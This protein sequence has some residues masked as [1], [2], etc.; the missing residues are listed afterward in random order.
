MAC[1]EK[2]YWYD[3]P[4]PP[5]TRYGRTGRRARLSFLT[6]NVF[7][8]VIRKWHKASGLSEQMQRSLEGMIAP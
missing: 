3:R 7:G 4:N 6:V 1:T 5:Q 2:N 8:K